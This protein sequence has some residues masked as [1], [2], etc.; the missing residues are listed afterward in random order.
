MVVPAKVVNVA[1]GLP[2]MTGSISSTG[3]FT[4]RV[5]MA[6]QAY[7]AEVIGTKTS[8]VQLYCDSG[9]QTATAML[10]SSSRRR[11]LM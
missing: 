6:E 8:T 1:V 9:P 3:A 10:V 4:A 5:I 11:R 2:F 7:E